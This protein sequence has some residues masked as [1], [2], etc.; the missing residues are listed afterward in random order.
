MIDAEHA[1]PIS[2]QAEELEIS[3]STAY[4]TPRPI[5]DAALMLMRRIDERHM[6]YPFGEAACC[7][8][9]SAG[10]VSK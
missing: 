6:N 1:L 9:C 5:P 3:R 8:T 4:Y 2:R 10:K 7:A